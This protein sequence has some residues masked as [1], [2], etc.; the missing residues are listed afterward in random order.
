LSVE[1]AEAQLKDQE[2]KVYFKQ[3]AKTP[4]IVVRFQLIENTKMLCKNDK[5]SIPASL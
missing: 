3:N 1:I 2:L 5:Q 4:K